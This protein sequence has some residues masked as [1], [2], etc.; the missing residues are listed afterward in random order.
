[1]AYFPMF[2]D[3]TD[4]KCI[5]A[6][7]GN[8]A[9]RKIAVQCRFDFSGGTAIDTRYDIVIEVIVFLDGIY[10]APYGSTQCF[11]S[12]LIDEIQIGIE[13]NRLQI[14][15]HEFVDLL[16]LPETVKIRRH[17]GIVPPRGKVVDTFGCEP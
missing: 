15:E 2:V 1:M 17:P 5:V 10:I 4:K 9:A 8:V 6:G 16:N 13:G 12:C 7:G 11:Q 3:L 14:F